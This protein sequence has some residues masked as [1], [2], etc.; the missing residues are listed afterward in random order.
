MEDDDFT[1]KRSRNES[2]S[3]VAVRASTMAKQEKNRG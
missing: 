1:R 2:R 3:L